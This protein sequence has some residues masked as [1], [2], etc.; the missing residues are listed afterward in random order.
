MA[1]R[2]PILKGTKPCPFCGRDPVLSIG[3]IVAI[4]CKPCHVFLMRNTIDDAM[5]LWNQRAK[6]S[7]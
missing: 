5:A 1:V 2:T 3:K 7:K 6:Q 4:E